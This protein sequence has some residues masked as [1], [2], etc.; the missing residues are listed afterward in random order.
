MKNYIAYFLIIFFYLASKVNAKE[1]YTVIK[2]IGT[3]V[4]QKTGNLLASGDVILATEPIIFKTPDSKASVISSKKGRFVLSPG[5]SESVV[6]V[7]SSLI[8]PMSNISSR[9]GPILSIVDVQNYFSGDYLILDKAQVNISK[10]IF[11]MNDSSFFFFTFLHKGV[12]VNKK[13]SHHNE[14]LIIE[15]AELFKIDDKAIPVNTNNKV[16]VGYYSGKQALYL[17]EMN[18]LAPDLQNIKQEVQLILDSMSDKSSKEKSVE[19]NSYLNE[20][21]GKADLD[22]VNQWLKTEFNI[23]L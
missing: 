3:I 14:N 7:K 2:V 16:K 9:N 1:Q 17:N 15:R 22:H 6:D 12:E 13:L 19:I 20:F 18:L 11:P 21:Y 8:P 5:G 4:L 10:H 23:G